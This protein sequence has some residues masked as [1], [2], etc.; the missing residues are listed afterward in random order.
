MDGWIMERQGRINIH[1]RDYLLTDHPKRLVVPRAVSL[2]VCQAPGGESCAPS[3]AQK[4][5]AGPSP[6]LSDWQMNGG[7]GRTQADQASSAGESSRSLLESSGSPLCVR[8][9]RDCD[10]RDAKHWETP[11][12]RR[13]DEI[14]W[15]RDT[16]TSLSPTPHY[17]EGKT[18]AQRGDAT[19]RRS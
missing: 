14:Q 6:G 9:A 1:A 2:A 5:Q 3:R 8:L 18:E 16:R 15:P 10:S 12:P 19:V 7:G 11:L 4:P 13:Q 17:T